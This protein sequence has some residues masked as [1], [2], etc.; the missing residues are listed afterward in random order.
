[1]KG[2][3]GAKGAKGPNGPKARLSARPTPARPLGRW[4]ARG[5]V[6]TTMLRYAVIFFVIALIA[7]L[8][9][10]SGL[11]AGAAGIAQILFVVFLILAI[12]GFLINALRGPR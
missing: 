5:R 11:A 4:P 9:G 12:G 2:A 6:P 1:M 8:F 10:F 3:K 7:A